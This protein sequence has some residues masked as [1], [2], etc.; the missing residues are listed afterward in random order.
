MQLK[1]QNAYR[2]ISDESLFIWACNDIKTR[3]FDFT[4]DG[5]AAVFLL[6]CGG[7]G[8]RA[9]RE[10]YTRIKIIREAASLYSTWM[11]A[12]VCEPLVTPLH[13]IAESEGLI[14]SRAHTPDEHR[15]RAQHIGLMRAVIIIKNN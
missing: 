3:V 15:H 14:T 6:I 2:P 11:R 1:G 13:L 7:G 5:A 9:A 4:T 10:L 8:E 12:G